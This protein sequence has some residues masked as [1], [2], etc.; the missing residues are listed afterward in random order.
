MK[1]LFET[2]KI[3]FEEK[4]KD[5]R[6]K[7]EKKLKNLTEEYE[8][9]LREQE[10]E[11]KEEIENLSNDLQAEVNNHHDYVSHAEHEIG[12]LQ[13]KIETLEH[14]LNEAREALN[15]VQT[16]STQQM[17]KDSENY[18]RDKTEFQL[19]IETLTL[20]NNT[21]DKEITSLRMKKDQLDSLVLEKEAQI[22]SMKKEYDDDKK[23]IMLK[24]DNYKQK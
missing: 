21:K 9:K 22:S 6:N 8:S 4:L 16:Q 1:S 18:K 24:M 19:K 12:L 7:T 13:Q 2:E 10:T 11:L 3:R 5:E 17:E 14:F 20:E 15:K 23:D